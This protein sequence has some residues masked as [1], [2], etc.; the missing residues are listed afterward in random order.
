MTTDEH[1]LVTVEDRDS[2]RVLTLNR[3][4]VKNAIDMPLRVVLAE[5]VEAA[6]DDD[7]V[8]AIVLTGAGGAFCSGGDISTMARQAPELTRPRAQAAQRVIRALWRG[9]PVI[10]AVEGPAFG[11][12][13][14]L[15][16]ACD[17]VVAA[18]DSLFGTTF[19][20][21]GLA[22]DMGIFTS[23]PDRIGVAAAKQLLMFPRRISGSEA[24]E[25]GLVDS[26]VEP[27]AALDAALADAAAAAAGPPLALAAIKATLA[28]GIVDRD[29]RLDL[30]V[31][32][33]A[34]LFDTE[35]FAE[36]VQAF[37]AR[38]RP[39]FVGR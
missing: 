39:Q 11:A 23:L 10:A 27:G 7:S 34:V 33:Q 9:K 36:G 2:V 3:P 6:M 32:N 35:D 26:V 17:R 13:T 29:A 5:A 19:T 22:G 15:A 16:L 18:R 37:H 21:V 28:S 8:R 31:E 38:R 24:G 1:T 20:G 14:A 25:L 30:E 4:R 12:G